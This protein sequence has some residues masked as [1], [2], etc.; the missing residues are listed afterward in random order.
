[1]GKIKRSLFAIFLDTHTTGD[2]PTWSLCGDGF[3]EQT[4]DYG[5]TTSEEQYVNQDS[6]TQEVESYKLTVP[7]PM[8]AILGDPVFEYID[9][10]RKRRAVLDEAK[11]ECLFVYLYKDAASGLYEAEKSTCA[12]KINSFGGKAGEATKIDFD[13][14]LSGEPESGT[15]S[16]ESKAFSTAAQ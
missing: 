15:F 5:A 14:L 8:T 2:T 7:S 6:P 11:T 10:L 1:M 3:T 9:G 13:L 4:V 16:P 12:V